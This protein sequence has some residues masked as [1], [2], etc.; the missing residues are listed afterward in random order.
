M[1]TS[2]DERHLQTLSEHKHIY[3]FFINTGELVGFAPHIRGEVAA[4]YRH[5]HPHYQYRES[6]AAC[7]SEMIVTIYRWYENYTN[8]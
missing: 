3:D 2:E 7:I 1:S 4:A 6:C 5:W 8:K